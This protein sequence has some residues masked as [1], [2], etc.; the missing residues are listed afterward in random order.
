MFQRILVPIDGSE[1][2]EKTLPLALEFADRANGKILLVTV[3]DMPS[4]PGLQAE[5][6]L[7]GFEGDGSVADASRQGEPSASSRPSDRRPLHHSYTPSRVRTVAQNYLDGIADSLRSDGERVST[8][9]SA[10]DAASE[11]A[12]IG[13]RENVDLIAMATRGRSGLVR[14]L[15]GSVA[16][17]I[18]HTASSPMLMV[19]PETAPK[20]DEPAPPIETIIVPVDGSELSEAALPYAVS[21]ARHFSAKLHL[22]RTVRFP[23]V[24]S[25]DVMYGQQSGDLYN[26]KTLEE[27]AEEYVQSL[28]ERLKEQRVEASH[29]IGRGHPRAHIVESAEQLPGAMVVMCT[30]GA[31]GITRWVMGSVADGVIRTAPV[32]TLVIPPTALQRTTDK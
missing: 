12:A 20:K 30:R 5:D 22:T 21:L 28:L 15:L 27:Q 3:V 2:S 23:G 11:I 7:E 13:E 6:Q 1:L 32:P 17:R 31:S 4:G 19:R 16:D 24:Y 9:V 29:D 18:L 25:A 26:M 14:G 8:V 10:G